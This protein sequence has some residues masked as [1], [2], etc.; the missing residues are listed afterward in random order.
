MIESPSAGNM[1]AGIPASAMT[2]GLFIFVP[3][4]P[5][6]VQLRLQFNVYL[7][8]ETRVTLLMRCSMEVEANGVMIAGP[9]SKMLFMSALVMVRDWET[10]SATAEAAWLVRFRAI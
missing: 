1:S 5:S 8:A 9:T 2:R 3:A 4:P 6:G 10:R 7:L